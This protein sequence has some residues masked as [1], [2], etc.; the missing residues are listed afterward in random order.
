[1]YR[2]SPEVEISP[3]HQRHTAASHSRSTC[4][5]V[6]HLVARERQDHLSEVVVAVHISCNY[7]IEVL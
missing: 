1:M 3:T 6:P 5:R 4:N 2:A 7:V